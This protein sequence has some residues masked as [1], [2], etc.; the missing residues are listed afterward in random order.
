MA[1]IGAVPAPAPVPLPAVA[2]TRFVPEVA[3][4]GGFHSLHEDQWQT[5]RGN[6]MVNSLPF[7]S[8]TLPAAPAMATAPAFELQGCLLAPLQHKDDG[9]ARHAFYTMDPIEY[10]VG[11]V[12]LS[13]VAHA[14]GQLRI[15]ERVYATRTDFLKACRDHSEPLAAV[16]IEPSHFV[17]MDPYT[18]PPYMDFLHETSIRDIF[19]EGRRLSPAEPVALYAKLVLCLGP[20][21]RNV[22]RRHH[23]SSP[24]IFAASLH[25]QVLIWARLASGAPS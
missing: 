20:V 23:Q 7:I 3:P 6:P 21:A 9:E 15:F 25:S 2:D 8:W 5:A 4:A 10:Q 13:A 1:T 24:S 18:G 16:M 14:M 19:F 22:T 11:H 17:S 12:H